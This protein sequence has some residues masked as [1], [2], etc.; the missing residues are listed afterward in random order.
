MSAIKEKEKAAPD[1]IVMNSCLWDITRYVTGINND[2]LMLRCAVYKLI[3]V[4]HFS[5]IDVTTN[6][7]L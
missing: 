6:T 3:R 4:E 2:A 5:F 1:V 7:C